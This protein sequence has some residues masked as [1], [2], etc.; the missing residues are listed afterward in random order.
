MRTRILSIMTATS[1]KDSK[2][3][4]AFGIVAAILAL[5]GGVAFFAVKNGVLPKEITKL[6]GL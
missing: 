6:L 1:E 3:G 2:S 5:I 4:L